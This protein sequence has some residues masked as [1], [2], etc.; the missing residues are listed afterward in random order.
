MSECGIHLCPHGGLVR[1]K[2][3]NF[4]CPIKSAK[5]KINESDYLELLLDQYNMPHAINSSSTFTWAV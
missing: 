4:L 3:S 2:D 5:P 1:M